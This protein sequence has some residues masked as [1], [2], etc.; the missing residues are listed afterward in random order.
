MSNDTDG[1]GTVAPNNGEHHSSETCPHRVDILM[2]EKR[3]SDM[4]RELF[5]NGKPGRLDR[6]ESSLENLKNQ[7]GKVIVIGAMIAGASGAGGAKLAAV[8]LGA[9]ADDP[10]RMVANPNAGH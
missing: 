7:F 3:V 1:A 10:P 4:D 8:I 5:G 6:I 2:I 9:P